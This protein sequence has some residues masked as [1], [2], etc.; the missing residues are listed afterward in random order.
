MKKTNDKRFTSHIKTPIE[1]THV[2]HIEKTKHRA[3]IQLQRQP[4]SQVESSHL[5]S[6][7]QYES[8][9]TQTEADTDTLITSRTTGRGAPSNVT[10][11]FSSDK[12]E[13]DGDFYDGLD[14]DD[15]PLLRTEFFND[16][17]K[18]IVSQNDSPDIGFRY[19]INFYR[20]C[21][22]GCIYCYARPTHEYLNLSAGLDFES[23]IFVKAKAPELLREKL[24]SPKWQ[25]ELI[26]MSGVTDCYQPAERNFQL[27]RKCLEVLNEFKNP[28]A[29]ITKNSL[30]TRDID[31]LKELSAAD[32]AHVTISVTSLNNDLARRMEPRTSSPAARL[33]AIEDLAKASIPVGVNVAPVVP[34][35]SDQEIPQILKAAA[36]AG[37]TSASWVPVRLPYS[38][39]DLFAQW[40]EVHYPEK[41]QKVLS[42]I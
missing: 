10:H 21:E 13:V 29:I 26:V 23:K 2:S 41:K 20:G 42:A 34:G 16:A 36:D 27:A 40:L 17:S 9:D 11:R 32:C 6:A 14:E 38:V 19:S 3:Q 39:K 37:A 1:K 30:V 4:Y 28:I 31:I 24:N 33:K 15:K 8:S 7:S 35:L 22:H 5:P 12:L 18:S 25:P